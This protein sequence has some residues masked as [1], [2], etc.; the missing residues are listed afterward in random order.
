MSQ[1]PIFIRQH[2]QQAVSTA[3][4]SPVS[5]ATTL[6]PR[7]IL[8]R[9]VTLTNESRNSICQKSREHPDMTLDDLA[10]WAE[11][12]LHLGRRPATITISNILKSFYS[13][14]AIDSEGEGEGE[15]ESMKLDY[16]ND[17]LY[18]SGQTSLDVSANL[19]KRVSANT[20]T[21]RVQN[22]VVRHDI[23]IQSHSSASS[24]RTMQV[25]SLPKHLFPVSKWDECGVNPEPG[26][27]PRC[28][29]NQVG[30]DSILEAHLDPSLS[31]EEFAIVQEPILEASSGDDVLAG[32]SASIL[33]KPDQYRGV[34][35][36]PDR[37]PPKALLPLRS[38]ET[39]KRRASPGVY[40]SA[41]QEETTDLRAAVRAG[42]RRAITPPLSSEGC[43]SRGIHSWESRN[44]NTQVPTCSPH[45]LDSISG[46]AY[47]A[48]AAGQKKG[49]SS[50]QTI[51]R[52][53]QA[54]ES[55]EVA[56]EMEFRRKKLEL[57]EK[58]MKLFERQVT[59]TERQVAIAERQVEMQTEREAFLKQIILALL[60][61]KNLVE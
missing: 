47:M 1:H 3:S 6:V 31:D 46:G 52:H 51:D 18:N 22:L 8:R 21:N 43:A 38:S 34:F 59:A 44:A 48:S 14:L 35:N 4:A 2:Q 60:K 26:F 16:D 61:Q 49:Q 24:S 53:I 19:Q 50:E 40:F 12:E 28:N 58:K 56:P 9:R 33:Q 36:I 15:D 41:A 45:G 23:E 17:N 42:K 30:P 20:A 57:K 27:E 37:V 7:A 11:K 5:S 55:K 39:G 13:S 29:L 54:R 25:A 10:I 32:Q